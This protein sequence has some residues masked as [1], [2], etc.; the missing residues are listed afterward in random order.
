MMNGVKEKLV[1]KRMT[2]FVSLDTSTTASGCALFVDGKLSETALINLSGNKNTFKRMNLM[3]LEILKQLSKWKPDVIWIEHPQGEGRN[4]LVVNM[5]SEILGAVRAYAVTKGVDYHEINPSEWRKYAGLTQ[6]SKKRED[7]KK[8]SLQ[9]VREQ[10]NIECE[11]DDL[12]DAIAIGCSVLNYYENL[13][14]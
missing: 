10:F 4:V 7:L 13:E 3:I 12:A 2:R 9:Y 1:I 14:K 11:T 8:Q 6:G 5:L